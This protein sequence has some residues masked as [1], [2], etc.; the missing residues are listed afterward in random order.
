MSR[1]EIFQICEMFAN[2]EIITDVEAFDIKEFNVCKKKYVD[3][4]AHHDEKLE[5]FYKQWE[6]DWEQFCAPRPLNEKSDP[7]KV[8]FFCNV[9]PGCTFAQN[10]SNSK[11]NAKRHV[12]ACLGIKYVC[13][14]CG[15]SYSRKEQYQ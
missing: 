2:A 15:A 5:K 13:V 3:L 1:D 11:H 4:K 6:E 12:Q 9:T 8:M 10:V 14:M 7:Y